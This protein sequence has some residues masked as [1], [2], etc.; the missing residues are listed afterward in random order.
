[1]KLGGKRMPTVSIDTFFACSLI[2]CVAL[3]ATAS[4]AG[5]MQTKINSLQDRN[6]DDYLKTIAEQIVTS[7]GTPTDWGSNGTTV[8]EN[9]GLDNSASPY[10]YE[11]DID[12]I[13]RLS[14]QS[15]YSLSY[16]QVSQ[17]ARLNN[18]ALGISISQMLTIT[19]ELSG[20]TTVGD[21]TTYTFTIS[22]SQDQ[23]PINASLHCYAVA[24]DFLTDVYNTTSDAGV[25][26]VS[27][28]IPNS[29]DGPALLIVFARASFE[30]RLTAYEVYSFAHLSQ[31]PLPNHT[32]LG[33]SPLNYTLN[34]NTKISDITVDDGYAFSYT[35]QSN[36]TSTSNTTY[37]IPAFL[38]KSPIVLVISGHNDTASFVEWIAYPD[39]PL[40]FGANF[41]NM[42]KNVFVYTASVKETLY[43]LTL[44]FGDV[45]D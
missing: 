13:T 5:T 36:L 19:A 30:D 42:E 44:S 23:G 35:Y 24:T 10:L 1:L 27:V 11:L 25:G 32:F 41:A 28:Q 34:L 21:E 12:K 3:L 9:F 38:D 7:I 17:A 29:S 16:F 43:K 14:S 31:E 2:V 20:N 4:F 18:L 15:N 40:E 33:L 45:A 37:A 26:T 39:I 22:V 8:P 6:K